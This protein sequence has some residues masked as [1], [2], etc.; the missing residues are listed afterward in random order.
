MTGKMKCGNCGYEFAG[1][2]CVT[3][4]K[5]EFGDGDIS[6]CLNCGEVHQYKNGGL[7]L[8]D[9]GTLPKETQEEILKINVA[10]EAVIKETFIRRRM[11]HESKT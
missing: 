9:I 7:E 3:D 11:R 10:R 1:H 4:E 5:A 8:I 6:I 2:T